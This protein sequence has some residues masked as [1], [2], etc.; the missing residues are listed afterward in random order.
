V[1]KPPSVMILD[2]DASDYLPHLATLVRD[3][4][5]LSTA[6]TA[7]SARTAWAGQPVVLGQPDL[8]AAVLEDLPGVRWVQST[9]AGVTPLLELGRRDFLLTGVK[10]VFGP[11][12]AEYVL[13]V[14]LARELKLAERQGHQDRRSWWPAD[15]GSLQDKTLGIMGTGSIGGCVAARAAAFGLRVIGCSRS[16][17]SVPGFER[18]FPIERLDEFLPLVDYLVS[19][20]PATPGTDGLLDAQAFRLM[21]THCCLVNVGRGNVI[22]ET[23]LEEALRQGRIAGA[24]LDVFRQ[25]PL[26]ADSPLW[27]TPGLTV[28][29]H[30]AAKS[31]PPGIAHIFIENYNRYVAGQPLLHSIDF[32]RGY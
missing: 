19:V 15:S 29:A 24:V 32:E 23:A 21:R 20:L 5:E 28:T 31:H 17:E 25:E 7:A 11:Q 2:Q 9:W 22:D 1:Q 27:D 10:E 18:V 26:P 14:L 6:T 30:V 12:M 16:G 8:V 3:G 13:G 4:V